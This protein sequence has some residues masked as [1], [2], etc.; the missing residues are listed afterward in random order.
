M[1]ATPRDAAY[2]QAVYDE[3][4][5]PPWDKGE[6]APPLVRA[7]RGARLPKGT[8]ALTP[9]C[10]RGHEA[11]FLAREGFE[12]TAVDFAPGAVAYLKARAG[13]LPI[14]ALERDLFS[15]GEDMAGRFDLVVEHTC[16]CAI[17]V[18][19]RDAYAEVV[20]KVL[21]DSGRIIGLFYETEKEDG[22]PFRTTDEDVRRHF[23][24]YF[25]ILG[26]ARPE[27]SFEN[28]LGKE[29]LVEMRKRL[30]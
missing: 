14:Q 13:G 20:A 18:E 15:L 22:P 10:G 8:R 9:G 24:G 26:C 30:R 4:E 3:H 16:F 28:R 29:W 2:W 5:T 23:E 6:P 25:D 7:V 17:P 1:A 21:T 11:L 27:D 19:M 12:V